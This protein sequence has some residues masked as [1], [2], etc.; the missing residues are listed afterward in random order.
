MD[1]ATRLVRADETD[2]DEL[3][4]AVAT[5]GGG[6]VVRARDDR[7]GDMAMRVLLNGATAQCRGAG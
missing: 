2:E 1:L 6:W 4:C 7:R 3:L 5:L